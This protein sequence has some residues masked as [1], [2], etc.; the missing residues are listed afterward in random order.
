MFVPQEAMRL[1]WWEVG[2]HRGIWQI[3]FSQLKL[4]VALWHRVGVLFMKES[5]VERR[6]PVASPPTARLAV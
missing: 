3:Q 1:R 2:T 4:G 5:A 6:S